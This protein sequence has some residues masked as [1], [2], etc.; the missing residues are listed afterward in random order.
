[1]PKAE[2][3]S[4]PPATCALHERSWLL[5][6]ASVE[7]PDRPQMLHAWSSGRTAA[8]S[9]AAAGLGIGLE[10]AGLGP[11]GMPPELLLLLAVWGTGR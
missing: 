10:A 2:S 1:M 5:K 4:G 9:G 6:P 7:K 3:S 11:R 8:A